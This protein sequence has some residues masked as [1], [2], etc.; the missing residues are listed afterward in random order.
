[1]TAQHTSISICTILYVCFAAKDTLAFSTGGGSAR[2][3]NKAPI[4]RRQEWQRGAEIE[5]PDLEMLF[6]RISMASPLAK[7]VM[8]GNSV[9]GFAAIDDD[10]KNPE[11]KWKKMESNSKK[12]VHRIDKADK[13]QNVKTPLLRFRSTLKGPC[14][15]ERFSNMLMDLD[16]R[17]KWDDQ[18]A[19]VEEMYPIDDLDAVN[20]ILDNEDKYGTCSRVGVGYTQTKQGIISPREQLTIVG[21]QEFKNGATILWGT[22]MEEYHN[23]LL[24]EGKRHTRA[25]SHLFAATLAPTGPDEFDVEYLL[26]MDVGGGLPHFMTTP[27][28]ADVVKKMFQHAKGYFEGGDGSDLDLYLKSR[29]QEEEY[30]EIEILS[31]M[32]EDLLDGEID[33]SE[34]HSHHHAM[35][36]IESLLFTP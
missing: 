2:A 7:L 32:D 26:Q 12:T 22:E 18:I 20:T 6:D 3:V 13:F 35:K 28:L 33:L 5:L 8:E 36:D 10:T 15:G 21:A 25:K 31:N 11:I 24:P 34:V 14:I 1:M 19:N 16:E 17:K 23:H 30:S 29:Q 9:G 4:A 27:A